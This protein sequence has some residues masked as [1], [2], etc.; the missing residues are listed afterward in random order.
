MVITADT[1]TFLCIF[2]LFSCDT[3]FCII[4]LFFAKYFLSDYYGGYIHF[5]MY[6][7]TFLRYPD[8]FMSPLGGSTWVRL[9]NMK[10]FHLGE[11]FSFR[12]YIFRFCFSLLLL[13]L[14]SF[15]SG[16]NERF[17]FCKGKLRGQTRKDGVENILES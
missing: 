8:T 15:L 5:F 12:A 17:R 10:C 13:F 4:L 16:S 3:F 11:Y 7:L 14:S 2:S 1:S 6:I 9:N